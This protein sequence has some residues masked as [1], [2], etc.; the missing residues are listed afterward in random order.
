VTELAEYFQEGRLD[1]TEFDERAT[2]A[3]T[4]RTGRD[5]PT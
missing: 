3:L 5:R 2:Q 4:A 1:Q